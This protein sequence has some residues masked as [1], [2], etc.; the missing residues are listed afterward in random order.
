MVSSLVTN[1]Q[2][3]EMPLKNP[4]FSSLVLLGRSAYAG[5]AGNLTT[6]LYAMPSDTD[7]SVNGSSP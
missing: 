4:T 7:I 3:I 6:S 2:M 1:E 5:S